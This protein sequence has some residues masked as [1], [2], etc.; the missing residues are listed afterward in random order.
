MT[1]PDRPLTTEQAARLADLLRTAVDA[2]ADATRANWSGAA[3]AEVAAAVDA[4]SVAYT[5]AV[6]AVYALAGAR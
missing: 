5:A 2:A 4:A 6:D 3:A 1:A